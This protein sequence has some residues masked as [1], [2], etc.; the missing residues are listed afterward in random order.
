[1]DGRTEWYHAQ[2]I[3]NSGRIGLE[4]DHTS[5][6][7]FALLLPAIRNDMNLESNAMRD[8]GFENL[9]RMRESSST[10]ENTTELADFLSIS[11]EDAHKIVEADYIF[12]DLPLPT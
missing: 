1:M 5:N 4:G 9:H 7:T 10:E 8:A 12:S 2:T 6:K 3:G 11:E